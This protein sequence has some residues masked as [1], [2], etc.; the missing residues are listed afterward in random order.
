MA[1]IAARRLPAVNRRNRIEMPRFTLSADCR[2]PSGWLFLSSGR[3][4]PPHFRSTEDI[5]KEAIPARKNPPTLAED[6]I[7]YPEPLPARVPD[8]DLIAALDARHRPGRVRGSQ[9]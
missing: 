8:R 1:D 9:L 2:H 6:K 3:Q 7:C 4:R 5:T